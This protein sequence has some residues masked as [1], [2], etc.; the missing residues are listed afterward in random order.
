VKILWFGKGYLSKHTPVR[1]ELDLHTR[2]P[3]ITLDRIL[4]RELR[5]NT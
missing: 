5:G 1:N 2:V 4:T 3:H